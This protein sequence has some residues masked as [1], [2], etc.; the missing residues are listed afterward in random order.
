L[1]P[2]LMP[3]PLS[4]ALTEQDIADIVAFLQRR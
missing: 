1:K 4:L 3:D 2:S